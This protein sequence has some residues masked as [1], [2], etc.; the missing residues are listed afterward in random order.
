MLDHFRV[1]LMDYSGSVAAVF[2][3]VFGGSVFTVLAGE[4]PTPT[5][6]ALQE[7]VYALAILAT[8]GAVFLSYIGKRGAAWMEHVAGLPTRKEFQE[9]VS[10][11]K[12][13]A[14][15]EDFSRLESRLEDGIGEVQDLK[16]KV[17]AMSGRFE[18]IERVAEANLTAIRDRVGRL[19]SGN[20]K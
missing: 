19:E 12:D 13:M 18:I 14:T 5:L 17:S 7:P 6:G 3:G 20:G 1:Q 9:C 11:L 8:L 2:A 4:L 15:K 10:A 16:F